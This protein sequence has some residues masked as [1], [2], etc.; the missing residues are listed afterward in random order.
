MSFELY[1][2]ELNSD[3]PALEP[4]AV[5]AVV[6][7]GQAVV[8]AGGT[9]AACPADGTKVS[10]LAL[11]AGSEAGKKI[12]MMPIFPWLVFKAAFTGDYDADNIGKVFGLG[13]NQAVDFTDTTNGLVQLVGQYDAATVLVRFIAGACTS[14]GAAV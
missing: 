2:N 9:Y 11:S 12:T 7:P 14:L 3:L 13:A 6:A 1:R 8:V 4:V 5:S 10:G